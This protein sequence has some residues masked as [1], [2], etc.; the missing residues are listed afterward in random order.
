M[1]PDRQRRR[2]LQ[3]T[4]TIARLLPAFGLVF[5]SA[6]D[7]PFGLGLPA[8]RALEN[9]AAASLAG[10]FALSGAYQ[11]SQG[12]AR[13]ELQV[14]P[15]DREH[16]ATSQVEALVA[17][18]RIYFRGRDFLARHMGTD[19]QSQALLAAAGNSWWVGV[20]GAQP[21]RLPDFTSPEAFRSTFLGSALTRR[22]DH[23]AV[24]GRPA[25]ELWGPR[26]GVFVSAQQPYRLL[27]VV[28]GAQ[29]VVDGLPGADFRY[30]EFGRDFGIAPPKDV[31]DFTNLSTQPPIYTVVSV[32]VSECAQPCVVAAVVRN[33]G[34][35]HAARAPSTVRFTMADASSGRPLAGC[36]TSVAPDVGYNATTRVSC[37]I[38]GIGPE[39]ANAAIVTATTD[40]PGR[41]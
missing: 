4:A 12:T 38:Y 25:V 13:I 40:N 20:S 6:C 34:G 22:D 17:G 1:A 27:R 32:D 23:A 41:G 16:I 7:L 3:V 5:L 21:P 28:E 19:V 9:G 36:T 29:A 37:P 18:G 8:T 30:S 2:H 10:S 35:L 15:P 31:I 11:D 24:D 39:Q 14:A 26:A 33:L